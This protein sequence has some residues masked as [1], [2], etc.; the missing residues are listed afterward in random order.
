MD[1]KKDFLLFLSVTNNLIFLIL[2]LYSSQQDCDTF[3]VLSIE[4]LDTIPYLLYEYITTVMGACFST[5][6]HLLE[7]VDGDEDAYK[8]RFREDKILGE[9]AYDT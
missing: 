1:W 4:R 2:Y 5:P 3:F 8:Q 6:A 9:G 7:V